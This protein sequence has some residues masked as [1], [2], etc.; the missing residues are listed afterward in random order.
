MG[1]SCTDLQENTRIRNRRAC[2]CPRTA[3][4][5]QD[6]Y[7]DGHHQNQLRKEDSMEG[8]WEMNM[9]E[10]IKAGGPVMFPILL[11]SFFALAIV[12]EKLIYF[13][14]LETNVPELKQQIME[15]I[16]NNNIKEAVH[17]CDQ[18][19]APVAKILRAGLVKYGSSRG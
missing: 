16:K 6:Q 12:I 1:S 5:D 9:W 3:G 14:S 17:L 18:R 4:L 13:S 11:C 7:F 8:I 2:L 15:L 19:R 10:L